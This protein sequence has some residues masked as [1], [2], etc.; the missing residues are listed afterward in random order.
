M[1]SYSKKQK[2]LRI[3]NI[4]IVVEGAHTEKVYYE[5]FASRQSVIKVIAPRYEEDENG[6]VI[7]HTGL[8]KPQ[9]LLQRA[10]RRF[11]K[12]TTINSTVDQVWFVIDADKF[13]DYHKV[14]EFL[15]QI[16]LADLKVAA[17][18]RHLVLS[19]PC[20]ETWQYLHTAS[21]AGAQPFNNCAAITAE[22]Q[23][24]TNGAGF[25]PTLI[26]K[27]SVQAAIERARA[28]DNNDLVP[29]NPGTRVYHLAEVLLELIKR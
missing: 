10:I 21:L 5:Y 25:N 17:D 3:Q 16:R 27:E 13:S 28:I 8:V 18:N 14:A 29:P 12:R 6:R 23:T 1:S 9:H 4:F 11:E 20:F 15:E 26:T 22:L 7:D 24:A 2:A 19:N